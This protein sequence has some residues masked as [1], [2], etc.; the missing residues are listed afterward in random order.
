MS[1]ENPSNIIRSWNLQT[2]FSTGPVVSDKLTPPQYGRIRTP[3]VTTWREEQLSSNLDWGSS[4]FS[5]YL[6]ES[7]KVIA[8][9]YL[10]I[11]LPAL[12][13]GQTYKNY[14]GLYAM[15]RLRIMSAGTEVYSHVLACRLR[16]VPAE[17]SATCQF[18][19]PVARCVCR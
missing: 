16:D 6:P 14:C 18:V 3:F 1:G 4:Q 9:I 13:P 10:R 12:G 2:G 7:L 19:T 8:S 11:N 5:I 15:R 17:T